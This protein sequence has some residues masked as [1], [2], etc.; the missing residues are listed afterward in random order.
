MASL[1]RGSVLAK[2]RTG[3]RSA[4]YAPELDLSINVNP[5]IQQFMVR[6]FVI[7]ALMAAV[8]TVSPR[9]KAVTIL[10]GP[11]FTPAT[12]APLAGLLSL[13]TDV[14][15]RI[16]VFVSDGTDFWERDFYNFATTNSVPLLGFK[17]GRTNQIL[18]AVYDKERNACTATQLL[19][20]VTAPLPADFPHSTVLQ[21]EPSE[22]EPGYALFMVSVTNTRNPGYITIMD[23]SGDVVWYSTSPWA[24]AA[25]VRQLDDG[26][27]F[28]EEDGPANC[29]QEINLLGETVR[30]WYSPPG[31]P[32]NSHEALAT[33]YGTILF[34]SDVSEVVSNFPSAVNPPPNTNYTLI[35]RTLDDNPVVEIS[36]TNAA[37][38]NAWSYLNILDPTRVTYLTYTLSSSYGVDN[39][40]ANALIDDTND[41]SFIVSLR[42]QNAVFKFSRSGQLEWIL[43]P[44]ANWP[45]NFQQYLFT[46][47]G[48]PFDWNYGQHA[49]ELTPQGTLM[50]YNDNNYQASPFAIPLPDQD[51][52]SSAVEYDL[53]EDNMEVSEVWNSSWQTNQDRL[54]TPYEGRVQWLP[55]TRNVL[56]TY[57]AVTYVNGVHPSSYAPG[58]TMVRII[59][60][61]HD[62]VPQVVFDLSF[63]DYTNTSPNYNG[64]NS[65]RAYQISDLYPHPAEAVADLT[66]NEEDQIPLLEFSGDPTQSYTIQASTDLIN[67]TTIGTPVQE[68]GVG[69]FDFEDLNANQFTARYYRVVTQ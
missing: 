16:S 14:D 29:F 35:T 42:N 51:N 52:Y 19:T 15:S 60:Y 58:A 62:P 53:D 6:K 31:Y 30:T 68:G 45:T 10:S 37:L 34:L 27:L 7:T 36:A 47:V 61:T 41:D 11:S 38:L 43:G 67:W 50:L 21:S 18:V 54:F 44:P 13:T 40:H 48:T 12:N 49:P 64:Y 63:F 69:D 23:N 28:I 32:V 57:S 66:V 65:Y 59:E 3:G 20:F 24:A 46:P 17:P 9:S 5:M 1:V 22:M 39:E 26:D 25:D 56:V 4:P 8:L 55:Q 33:D 2:L